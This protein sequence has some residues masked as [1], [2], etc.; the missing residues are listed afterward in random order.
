MFVTRSVWLKNVFRIPLVY[1]LW[2]SVVVE[3][4]ID[5]N[6]RDN[7]VKETYKEHV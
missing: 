1:W 4:R 3:V 6:N 2:L 7:L 5:D